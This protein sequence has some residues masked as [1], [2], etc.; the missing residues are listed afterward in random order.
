MSNITEQQFYDSVVETLM[1]MEEGVEYLV[2]E[3]YW[4]RYNIERKKLEYSYIDR[5]QYPLK[6]IQNRL[7]VGNT[8]ICNV[9]DCN[10]PFALAF[11]K[12]EKLHKEKTCDGKIVEI[13]GK[14]YKL[15]VL[16]K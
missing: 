9:K 8:N 3:E 16:E 2:E 13:D 7:W 14:K 6:V 4:N 15:T 11:H 10:N 5:K 12:I 1:S